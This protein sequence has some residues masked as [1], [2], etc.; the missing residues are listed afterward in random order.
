LKKKDAI[1]LFHAIDVNQSGEI[2]YT[3]FIA[4]FMGT[5]LQSDERYLKE[6]FKQFDK[7]GD[8]NICKEE[9]REVLLGDGQNLTND[10]EIDEIIQKCD[11]NGDGQ[12]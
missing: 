9:L 1:R 7:N 11:K 8:G 12:I 5:K 4:S 6:T 3:E 2:D 10:K